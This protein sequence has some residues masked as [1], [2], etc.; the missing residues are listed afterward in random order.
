MDNFSSIFEKAHESNVLFGIENREGLEELPL[1]ADHVPF[2]E[3]FSLESPMRYWHDVG[4]GEIKSQ[5]GLFD[6]TERLEALA[7]LFDRLS[8][9]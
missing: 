9:A 6:H 7:R 5:Y 4:H 1:D 2:L 3:Q 8:F